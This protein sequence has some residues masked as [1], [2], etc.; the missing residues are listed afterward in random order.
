MLSTLLRGMGP[1]GQRDPRPRARW[2]GQLSSTTGAV[3]AWDRVGRLVGDLPCDV[4]WAGIPAGR[5]DRD[6]CAR[7]SATTAR[8]NC[9]TRA[10]RRRGKAPGHAALAAPIVGATSRQRDR[11]A[12]HPHRGPRRRLGRRRLQPP[13]RPPGGRVRLPRAQRGCRGLAVDGEPLTVQ[14]C[15]RSA[16]RRP[17]LTAE[18]PRPQGARARR[19][20]S[21]DQTPTDAS[22]RALDSLGLDLTEHARDGFREALCSARPTPPRCARPG[23][24]SRSGS[25]TWSRRTVASASRR[26]RA[27][28]ADVPSGRTEYR[29]LADYSAE[30][31]RWPSRPGPGQ[32]DHAQEHD[33]RGAP[34]RGHRDHQGRPT[35]GRQ[36]GLPADG[37]APRAR[38]A[39]RRARDGVGLRDGQRRPRRRRARDRPDEQ[40]ARDRRADRQPRRLQPV[41]RGGLRHPDHGFGVLLEAAR[42]G[43]GVRLQAAQL[44]HEGRRRVPRRG[45]VRP[46]RNRFP[47]HRPQP[48]LRRLLGRPRREPRSRTTTPTAAP[49]RS[50]SR[51]RRTSRTSSRAGR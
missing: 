32:A 48:Q 19:S 14:A 42:R 34:G 33:A 18:H 37:R 17:S 10:S 21:S 28:G 12:A 26:S 51:R 36:A 6:R 45:R 5:N 23:W 20:S 11:A 39:E 24:R 44:P 16:R 35:P 41:A 25:P 1:F 7:G 38:V 50:P 4:L 31:K 15:R 40:G 2:V 3:R 47:G 29:R 30:M 22:K 43:R 8:R 27:A 9:S 46:D 49:R 13:R